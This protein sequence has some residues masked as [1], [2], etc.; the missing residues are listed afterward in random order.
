[1]NER[2]LTAFQVL[3]ASEKEPCAPDTPLA[4]PAPW[5]DVEEEISVGDVVHL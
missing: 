5:K 1:M 4:P 2:M 3:I